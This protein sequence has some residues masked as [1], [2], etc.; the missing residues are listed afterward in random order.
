MSKS[1]ATSET[2]I[3]ISTSSSSSLPLTPLSSCLKGLWFWFTELDLPNV[4]R[5]QRKPWV[6]RLSALVSW[7]RAGLVLG[8]STL[9]AS[10]PLSVLPLLPLW[11]EE[12][13]HAPTVASIA[14]AGGTFWGKVAATPPTAPAVSLLSFS[15]SVSSDSTENRLLWVLLLSASLLVLWL[16]TSSP[17]AETSASD[18]EWRDLAKLKI[19]FQMLLDLPAIGSL[20]EVNPSWD[21]T[22]SLR[23]SRTEA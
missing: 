12:L 23:F 8:G 16:A 1:D 18:P 13:P 20:M 7:W 3:N 2:G 5:T 4:K 10:L 11:A 6:I 17:S 9:A 21:R 22:A 15:V 19:R 14:V